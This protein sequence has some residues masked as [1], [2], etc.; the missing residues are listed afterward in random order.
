MGHG[1]S[2]S[3]DGHLTVCKGLCIESTTSSIR[4]SF[5]A[6]PIPCLALHDLTKGDIRQYV[7]DKLVSNPKMK[8]LSSREPVPTGELVLEIVEAAHGVFLCS[9]FPYP[10][11]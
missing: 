5:Q 3:N 4:G 6:P 1:E 8:E 2:F 11:I 9:C 7:D 10:L